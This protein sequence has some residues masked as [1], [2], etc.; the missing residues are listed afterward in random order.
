MSV[1]RPPTKHRED[2]ARLSAHPPIPP[3]A[4]DA[5]PTELRERP[6]WVCWRYEERQGRRTK[7]PLSPHTGRR[8]KTDD[9][10]TWG[11]FAEA[12]TAAERHR[13]GLGYVFAADDPYVGIDLDQCRDP[14]TG[15]LTTVAATVVAEFDTYAEASVSGTGVHLIARGTIPGARRKSP[16]LD[17]E[18]YAARR[19]FAFTGARL[20]DAPATIAA[21]QPA[22]NHFYGATFGPEP[23]PVA[24]ATPHPVTDRD[25][26]ALL[27]RARSDGRTGSAFSSLW[28]GDT[29]AHHGDHSAA[30]LALCSHLAYWTGGDTARVDALFR[31]SAL[32]RPKWDERR[33]ALTYGER[34]IARALRRSTFHQA[35]PAPPDPPRAVG[36]PPPAPDGGGTAADADREDTD[37]ATPAELR[38]LLRDERRRRQAVEAERDALREEL[39]EVRRQ[40]R[41]L[42]QLQSGTMA[43][44]RNAR[45]KAERATALAVT[46]ET[47]S[48]ESRG[49]E[50]EDG[51]IRLPLARLAEQAGCSPKRA[52]AHL[53]RLADWGI[54]EK[55]VEDGLVERTDRETGARRQKFESAIYVKRNGSV[56]DVL[57]KLATLEPTKPETWGGKRFPACPDHPDAGSVKR[58]TV[59]CA[60]CGQ[61][62]NQG[63]QY[64]SA[65]GERTTPP[66]AGACATTAGPGDWRTIMAEPEPPAGQDDPPTVPEPPARK[67]ADERDTN[68]MVASSGRPHTPPTLDGHLDRPPSPADGVTYSRSADP[69]DVQA[70]QQRLAGTQ[71]PAP[72][73]AGAG[74]AEKPCF[75]RGCTQRFVPAG[76]WERYCPGCQAA[77]WR[78]P[79]PTATTTVAGASHSAH[80]AEHSHQDEQQVARQLPREAREGEP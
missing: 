28:H 76:R 68:G 80:L 54:I 16:G 13:W 51:F 52:G 50:R 2:H 44:Q 48:A 38:A 15:V 77:G 30:D 75:N 66:P 55:K 62:L 40:H 3:V 11:T 35:A 14:A 47:A 78:N 53:D 5:I 8:A 60:A 41:E 59:E 43:V 18:I 33:G 72:P 64:R 21:C 23:A 4:R 46:F 10:A 74:A 69:R 6:Q 71:A 49:Q 9:P 34:T 36:D 7:I 39:A 24:P 26:A 29:G 25:D 63:E 65:A 57:T 31:R 42:E 17:H 56:A 19:F 27:E 67:V 22:I 79:P 20:P 73:P 45:I 58:W 37:A 1:A 70:L 61:V 12:H 32:Y